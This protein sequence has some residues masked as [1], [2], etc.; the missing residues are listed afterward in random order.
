MLYSVYNILSIHDFS[1]QSKSI[2]RLNE[3]YIE[4]VVNKIVFY[5][6]CCCSLVC[7]FFYFSFPI[8]QFL[9]EYSFISL[10]NTCVTLIRFDYDTTFRYDLETVFYFIIFF[11]VYRICWLVHENW[12][13]MHSRMLSFQCKKKLTNTNR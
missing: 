10:L 7:Q 12:F 6:C 3:I 11:E 2:E 8:H 13:F 4:C 9:F 5:C 1:T